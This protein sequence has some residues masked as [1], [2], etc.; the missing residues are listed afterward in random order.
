MKAI[1]KF[2]WLFPFVFLLF[3]GMDGNAQETDERLQLE[4]QQ[5]DLRTKIESLKRGQD[6]LLFRKEFYSAD[7]KYLILDI[8][9]GQGELRYKN[10][11]LKSFLFTPSS[12]SR[13]NAVPVGSATVTK[14]VEGRGKR[15]EIIFGSSFMMRVRPKDARP[16][17]K[18]RVSPPRLFVSKRDIQSLFYAVE[19]GSKAYIRQ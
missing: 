3:S 1:A 17:P 6:L 14:K 9:A 4:K 5:K 12:K 8:P 7:S 16:S 19:E 2:I 15:Y 11:L 18:D 13:L 10:R